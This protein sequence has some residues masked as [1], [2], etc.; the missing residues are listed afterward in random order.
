MKFKNNYYEYKIAL[1][2]DVTGDGYI[3]MNVIGKC[4]ENDEVVSEASKN[5]I[6][7]RYYRSLNDYKF[8]R[9][10][11]SVGESIK[12]LM[13]ELESAKFI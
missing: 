11:Y 2:G 13:N 4:I 8:G 5:E 7:R 10:D 6:I 12:L 1:A 3:K 9:N